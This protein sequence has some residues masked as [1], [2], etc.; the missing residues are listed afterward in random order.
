VTISVLFI[1]AFAETFIMADNFLSRSAARSDTMDTGSTTSLEKKP[2]KASTKS[3]LEDEELA[4][5][6]KVVANMEDIALKALHV[7][8]DPSL[9]PWT[10][11]MF[12]LG[13]F[14]PLWQL[15]C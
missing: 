11:R 12:F 9:N 2:W 7:D 5:P 15:T 6:P 14:A 4:A 13:M 1:L 3:I 8:D 10:F